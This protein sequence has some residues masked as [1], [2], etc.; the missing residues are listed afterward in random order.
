MD[1]TKAE[2]ELIELLRGAEPFQLAIS[3]RNDATVNGVGGFTS[4]SVTTAP[5]FPETS[6]VNTGC[7]DRFD[8]A[9]ELTKDR[10]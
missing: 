6:P 10:E 9:W 4:C 2:K 3:R 5:P 8:Q 1:L 7:G